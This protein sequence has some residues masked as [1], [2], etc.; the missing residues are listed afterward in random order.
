MWEYVFA[1][2]LVDFDVRAFQD[3]ILP[4]DSDVV[5]MG[6]ADGRILYEA[7]ATRIHPIGSFW[8]GS[9]S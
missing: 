2:I 4:S 3:T 6:L 9:I 5:L 8:L 1:L 7:L